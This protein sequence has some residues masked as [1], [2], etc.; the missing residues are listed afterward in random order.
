MQ[1]L[2][3]WERKFGWVSFPGFLRYYAIL[4]VAVYLLQIVDPNIGQNLEFNKSKIL[5][6]EVWRVVTFLFA[7]RAEGGIDPIGAVFLVCM[8][9]IAFMMSDALEAVWGAFRTSLFYYTGYIGLVI[10]N[11]LYPFPMSG[12]GYFIYTAAFLSFATMFPKVEF[13]I[14]FIIPVQVRWLALLIGIYF[15][16]DV[17]ENPIF[18]GYLL[19]GFSNYIFWTGIPALRAAGRMM[20]AANRRKQFQRNATKDDAAFHRCATCNRTDVSDPEL[21][22]RMSM[23][24]NE[25]C[26]DHLKD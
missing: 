25:Y 22:F 9:G 10:A 6:G 18:I 15:V 5:D 19:L 3:K 8:V 11:F 26:K 14:M 1:F 17:F 7:S 13:L 12:S 23:D 16:M 20:Q 2:G 4:H 24:G 21:E